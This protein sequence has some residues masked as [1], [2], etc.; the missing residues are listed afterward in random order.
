M[1]IAATSAT[2][3]HDGFWQRSPAPEDAI[4]LSYYSRDRVLSRDFVYLAITDG[5]TNNFEKSVQS[6]AW[7]KRGWT[8]QERYLSQRVLYFC[9]AQAYSECRAGY[10]TESN[11]PV[12]SAPMGA[13]VSREDSEATSPSVFDTRDKMYERWHR[14]VAQYSARKLTYESDKLPAISGAAREVA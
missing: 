6:A 3:S 11:E 5:E 12:A 9:L 13:F 14:L 4:N 10:R 1:T 7:N 2:T 8:L